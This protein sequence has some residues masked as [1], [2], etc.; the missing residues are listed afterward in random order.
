MKYGILI[1]AVLL[2]VVAYVSV[3]FAHAED[4]KPAGSKEK[5][6]V[7]T[8]ELCA[9]EAMNRGQYSLARDLFTKVLDRVKDDSKRTAM[10]QEQVRVCDASIKQLAASATD[11]AGGSTQQ[12]AAN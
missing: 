10:I 2:G 6:P 1:F 11:P 9:N 7:A 3:P 4:K 5:D 8:M 12:P